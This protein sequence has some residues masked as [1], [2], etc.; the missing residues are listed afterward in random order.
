MREF[1]KACVKE[2]TAGETIGISLPGDGVFQRLLAFS[3]QHV[4]ADCL[5]TW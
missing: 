5:F 1:P 3:Y 4:N 2:K